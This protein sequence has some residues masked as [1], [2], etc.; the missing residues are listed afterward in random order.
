MK[1]PRYTG[2]DIDDPDKP[3]IEHSAIAGDQHFALGA[4]MRG[5]PSH[6]MR[7]RQMAKNTWSTVEECRA[8]VEQVVYLRRQPAL[9]LPSLNPHKVAN[10]IL[11][12]IELRRARTCQPHSLVRR[13]V[14]L[15]RHAALALPYL[16]SHKVANLILNEVELRLARPRPH[17][18]PPYIKVEA[19]PLCHL[20]CGACW[21]HSKAYKK[22]LH[23]KMHLTVDRVARIVH[24]IVRELVGV[25]LSNSGEPLLN[26]ELPEIVHYLHER[27][28]CTGF[29]TNLSVPLT[30]SQAEA[31]VSAGLDQML[32]S[33]DG[34]CEESYLKYRTG[35]NFQLVL[36]NVSKMAEAKRR[37]G[38][39]R[40]ILVWKMVVFP[41]NA[42]EVPIVGRTWRL[43]GFDAV[44]FVLDHQSAENNAIKAQVNREM[45]AGRKPCFWAW[46]STVIGWDGGVQPCCQQVN[47]IPLGN[48]A[49]QN[50][51]T[52]WQAEP[53][54]RLRAGFARRRYGEDM[55]PVCRR[56]I[57]L[58]AKAEQIRV[59]DGID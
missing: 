33:L 28:I 6:G 49:E 18:V 8:F 9:A 25:S 32:I 3:Q 21:H 22:T 39:R 10:L 16:T 35:G 26:R 44:E 27:R 51:R 38:A 42:H 7:K 30:S 1:V 52:I 13:A 56:C 31:F 20:S 58:P 2:R 23:N 46:N 29:P 12:E 37:L 55:H 5:A 17:S 14:Y 11:N 24:P 4:L 43:L 57:G 45:V 48:A 54:G 53:Y 36:E 59:G 50:I 47:E 34:A 40:P 15:Q 19:T 41:H